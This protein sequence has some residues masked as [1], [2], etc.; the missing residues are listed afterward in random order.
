[1]CLMVFV[2]VIATCT[3]VVSNTTNHAHALADD[4]G[5]GQP[6]ALARRRVRHPH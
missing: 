6:Q 4:P 1:M 2:Y 5:A 3:E